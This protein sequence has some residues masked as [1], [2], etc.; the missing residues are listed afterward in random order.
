MRPL[1][2]LKRLIVAVVVGVVVLIALAVVLGR[3]NNGMPP[4]VPVPACDAEHWVGTWIASIRA[5]PS[6]PGSSTRRSALS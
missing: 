4:T 2:L 5:T 3:R 6:T 1:R